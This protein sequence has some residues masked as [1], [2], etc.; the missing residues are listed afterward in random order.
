MVAAAGLEVVGARVDRLRL[1]AP[2]DDAARSF[3]IDTVSRIRGQIG[4]E[5]D[6]A[7]R[8]AVDVLLDADDPAGIARRDDVFLEASQQIVIARRAAT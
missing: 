6:G 4:D 7:D 3:V 1:A 5:L 8:H 2:V